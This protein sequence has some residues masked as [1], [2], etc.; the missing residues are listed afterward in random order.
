MN[1]PFYPVSNE[2]R[3]YGM[4]CHILAF[5]G[6]IVPFGTIIGPLIMWL[7]KKDQS[8]FINDQGKEAVNFQI[9]CAIYAIVGAVLCLIVIG[10]FLLIA[11]GI[12]WIIFVI[13]GSVKA[14]E[15]KLYRY[16]M[17][18]RFIK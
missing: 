8:A 6:F 13:I 14:N 7:I 18:L 11:L 5:S 12:F 9:S 15:G 3:T 10:V 16:P 4:L 17:T 1:Q 2:E